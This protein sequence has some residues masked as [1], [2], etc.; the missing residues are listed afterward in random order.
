[1]QKKGVLL[2]VQEE[3]DFLESI[4]YDALGDYSELLKS[5]REKNRSR[6]DSDTEKTE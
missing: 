6:N 3:Q 1:M 2:M 4:P 5:L